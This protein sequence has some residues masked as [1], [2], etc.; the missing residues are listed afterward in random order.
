MDGNYIRYFKD[1]KALEESGHVNL[2]ISEWIKAVDQSPECTS[3]EVEEEGRI[4]LFEAAHNAELKI[5]LDSIDM[6]RGDLKLPACGEMTPRPSEDGRESVRRRSIL[7]QAIQR[8]S[9]A[10]GFGVVMPRE[11]TPSMTM[12]GPLMK[13]S[14]NSLQTSMQVA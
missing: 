7:A 14:G 13:K 4:F 12:Y 9:V 2:G 5:W 8:A 3:F 11:T 10:S 1:H 6:I